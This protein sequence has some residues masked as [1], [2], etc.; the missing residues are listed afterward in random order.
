MSA[1]ELC[2]QC[3]DE[4]YP[5][6]FPPCGCGSTP[7]HSNTPDVSCSPKDVVESRLSC[8]AT[9]SG[10]HPSESPTGDRVE[11][12]EQEVAAWTGNVGT[13]LTN[14][15]QTFLGALS[16]LNEK[17]LDRVMALESD[18]ESLRRAD[19]SVVDR[20]CALEVLSA[21]VARPPGSQPSGSEAKLCRFFPKC[22]QG[23]SCRFLHR[24]GSGLAYVGA[25]DDS[26][27]VDDAGMLE[28]IENSRCPGCGFLPWEGCASS[29]RLL[30]TTAERGADVGGESDKA[31]SEI[32]ASGTPVGSWCRTQQALP[33]NMSY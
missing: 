7:K 11:V 16:G 2:N 23:D 19:S 27:N 1:S 20:I 28:R 30:A 29:C 6:E 18:L 10:G 21:V 8:F 22:K 24:V 14:Q 26:E 33:A 5:I 15:T 13:L 31:I 9:S 4:L 17:L 12:L 32:S 25:Q 3:G